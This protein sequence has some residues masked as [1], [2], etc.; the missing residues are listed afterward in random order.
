MLVTYQKNT[1]QFERD[2][3]GQ[4]LNNLN[5]KINSDGNGL[6]PIGSNKNH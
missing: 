4:I 6:Y 3:T 1:G 5:V 2:P